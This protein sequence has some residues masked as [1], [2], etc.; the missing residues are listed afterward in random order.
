[1]RLLS[2]ASV[3]L[4]SGCRRAYVG[5]EIIKT[6]WRKPIRFEV[7]MEIKEVLQGDVMVIAAVGRLDST[8][9]PQF[10]QYVVSRVGSAS[11]LV[12]DFSSLNYISSAGLRVV[13]LTAKKVKQSNG[14]LIVCEL[15][16]QIREVFEISGFLTILDVRAGAAEALAAMAA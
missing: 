5:A 15:K 9:A 13:L 12:L 3:D 4:E 16:D 11:R 2:A 10:E 1:M 14:R 8:T 7:I 6:A